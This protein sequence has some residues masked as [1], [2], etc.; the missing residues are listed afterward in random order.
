VGVEPK[1]AQDGLLIDGK[2][3]VAIQTRK[4]RYVRDQQHRWYWY[5]D[6]ADLL[7]WVSR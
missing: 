3:V 1:N 6:L 7:R 4:C 2:I 5:Q